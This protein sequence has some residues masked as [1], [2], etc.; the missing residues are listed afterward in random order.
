[1]DEI[2]VVG[3]SFVVPER[4]RITREN[5]KLRVRTSWSVQQ[6]RLSKDNVTVTTI[7][8]FRS[9]EWGD[10]PYIQEGFIEIN[11]ILF[12]AKEVKKSDGNS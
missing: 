4:F 7:C 6:D 10:K 9:K 12:R 2:E 11:G 5:R 8:H 1:M 3:G